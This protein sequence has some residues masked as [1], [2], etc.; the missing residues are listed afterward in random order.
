MK[1]YKT[2]NSKLVDNISMCLNGQVAASN[3]I[4]QNRGNI[5]TF[6]LSNCA[7]L[8][9]RRHVYNLNHLIIRFIWQIKL[10]CYQG[11]WVASGVISGLVS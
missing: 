3:F 8:S 9:T 1:L 11:D 5:L 10:F 2:N 6:L 4:R 7:Y